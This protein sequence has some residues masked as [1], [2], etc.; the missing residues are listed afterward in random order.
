MN[1]N[2]ILYEH[3]YGFRKKHSTEHAILSITEKIKTNLDKNIFSCGIFVDLEKAFDTVNHKI[4]LAKLEHLGNSCF[5]NKW[6]TSY[7]SK[8]SQC[9]TVNGVNSDYLPISCGVP[10]GSILGPLLIFIYINDMNKDFSHSTL[11]HFADVTNY[12]FPSP[13]KVIER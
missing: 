12:N 3:Q 1:S 6:L 8:R 9:V 11:Y 4:L 2:S 10:Q 7:L 13:K 5:S